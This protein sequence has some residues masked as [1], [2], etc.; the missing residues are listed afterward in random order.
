MHTHQIIYELVDRTKAVL[1]ANIPPR[2]EDRVTGELE[3]AQARAHRCGP[4]R[5]L[6]RRRAAA[7]RADA[8]PRAQVFELT[9]K[10]RERRDGMKKK[11]KVAG[12]K[13]STGEASINSQARVRRGDDVVHEGRVISLKHFKEDVRSVKKGSECGII[14][15]DCD[16]LK[17]GDLVTFYEVVSRKVGLYE[18]Q[19]ETNKKHPG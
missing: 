14:L 1:E 16:D 6:A 13:V 5:P 19:G 15:N 4:A 2:I 8:A 9:L 11:Q 17:P 18:G 12:G 10:A 7:P 3:V